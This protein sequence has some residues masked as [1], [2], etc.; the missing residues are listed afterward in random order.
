MRID[1]INNTNFQAGKLNYINVKPEIFTNTDSLKA[2]AEKGKLDISI[3]KKDG[4]NYFA[5]YDM[6]F[7]KCTKSFKNIL[8]LNKTTFCNRIG[9]TIHPKKII[10]ETL[11]ENV[12]NVVSEIAENIPKNYIGS[13][14]KEKLIDLVENNPLYLATRKIFVG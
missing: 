5:N 3:Y 10:P 9:L 6:Y 12:Y 11:S 4:G 7:V 8:K 1:K 2:L 13:K 14:I